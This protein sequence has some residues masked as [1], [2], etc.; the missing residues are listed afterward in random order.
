MDFNEVDLIMIK[1]IKSTLKVFYWNFT[2]EF[3]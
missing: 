1:S 3:N 2:G